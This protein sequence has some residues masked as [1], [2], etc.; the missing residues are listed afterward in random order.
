MNYNIYIYDGDFNSLICLINE[1][2]K[3]NIK[4]FNIKDKDYNAKLLDN[5]IYLKLEEINIIDKYLKYLGES[6][7]K[8]IYY[9]YLSNAENKELI[10]YYFLLNY[11]KYKE[12]IIY[13]R[14]LKCVSEA[15]RISKYVSRE[16]HRFKGFVRFKE[17]KNKVLYAEIEP[18]N[19]IL[20]I[21]SKHF[22][23]RLKNEYWI[24][25][26]VK[27]KIISL[28]DKNNYYV[29]SENEL[30]LLDIK[31]SDKEKSIEELWKT[32]YKTIG[33]KERKNEKC[34]MNFMPK[35]YWK[36]L[37]EMSDEIEDSSKW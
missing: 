29:V 37:I 15:L 4:P 13:M 11:L 21:L 19:N 6:I 8:T 14:N 23:Y 1:L 33:I 26:D 7:F 36:N 20:V 27:R 28:Y 22:K 2:L 31:Y 18:E 12:K 32:F 5:L 34:R 10:I 25:K 30:K 3:N 9:V 24:I 16:N 35:K 17:L